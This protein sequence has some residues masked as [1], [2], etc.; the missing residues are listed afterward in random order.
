MKSLRYFFVFFLVST[1]LCIA[2]YLAA[3]PYALLPFFNAIL[4]L[5]APVALGIYIYRRLGADWRVFGLGM[6]TWLGAQVLH[7]PFNSWTLL[8]ALENLGYG[9]SSAPGSLELAVFAVAVGLSAGVFEET[10]RYIVYSRWME[11]TR[12]WKDGLMFGA[13]HG[14]VEAIITGVMAL[15]YFLYALTARNGDL[16]QLTPEQLQAAQNF[17][18]AYWNNAWYIYLL[19]AAE[20]LSA[21]AFHLAAAL[22]V[23]RAV[24]RRSPFWFLAAVTLHTLF[25]TAAVFA[26]VTWG[27]LAA[28]GLVLLF[29][30]F[31]VGLIFYLR[32]AD[33]PPADTHPQPQGAPTLPDKSPSPPDHQKLEDSRYD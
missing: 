26:L 8:P 12:L 33:E 7:I 1:T 13:G 17:S 10:A 2:A 22:L 4:M 6:L 20:R 21:L 16:G 27:E 30:I 3:A 9:T 32:P 19:P 14:G 15:L 23:L 11:K 18:D 25:N 24:N 29:G 5:A 31:S 28:E